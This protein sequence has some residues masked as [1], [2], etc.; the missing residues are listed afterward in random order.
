MSELLVTKTTA[1]KPADV[2][3]RAVQFFTAERW[4][5]QSQNGSIATFIGMPRLHWLQMSLAVLLTLCLV[6]PGIIYYAVAIRRQR[7]E[8]SIAVTTNPRGERCL[9]MVTYPPGAESLMTS[10]LADLV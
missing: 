9:V 10:F 7:R 1:M 3:F 8:Q 2:M 5:V 4:R 6:I